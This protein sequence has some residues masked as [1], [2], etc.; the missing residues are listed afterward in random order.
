V[1]IKA[2]NCMNDIF[3]RPCLPK[4]NTLLLSELIP[5]FDIFCE[6]LVRQTTSKK[7]GGSFKTSF[8]AIR[9]NYAFEIA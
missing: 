7:E 8:S 4:V 3:N 1:K 6:M 2:N 5:R 9:K